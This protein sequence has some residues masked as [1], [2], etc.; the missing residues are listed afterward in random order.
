MI[1]QAT[2]LATSDVSELL[3]CLR[4]RIWYCADWHNLSTWVSNDNISSMTMPRLFMSC[5]IAMELSAINMEEIDFVL[6]T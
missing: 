2:D 4:A 1:E 5:E 3:I 6:L